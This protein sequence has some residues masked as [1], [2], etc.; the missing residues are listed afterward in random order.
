[1]SLAF[2]GEFDAS[3]ESLKLSFEERA[4]LKSGHNVSTPQSPEEEEALRCQREGI[5]LSEEM[6][7]ILK[8]MNLHP[9]HSCSTLNPDSTQILGLLRDKFIPYEDNLFHPQISGTN[10]IEIP[11][12]LLFSK[13]ITLFGSFLPQ[14]KP[15]NDRGEVITK[16]DELILFYKKILEKIN[17]GEKTEIPG[18]SSINS[19]S[20]K[21]EFQNIFREQ[22]KRSWLE[23]FVLN[24]DPKDDEN[25]KI[26]NSDEFISTIQKVI[27][28]SGSVPVIISSK[29]LTSSNSVEIYHVFERKIKN[30]I[31][32]IA[33]AYDPK[34]QGK[35]TVSRSEWK[36][37]Q[38]EKQSNEIYCPNQITL[39]KT[40]EK[41]VIF[42]DSLSLHQDA[43]KDHKRLIRLTRIQCQRELNCGN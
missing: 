6:K 13:K 36:K 4:D 35:Y 34:D 41:S 31:Q 23:S 20:E 14:E 16:G 11:G 8:K 3:L 33:C 43:L 39:K 9:C 38:K 10:G 42:N 28:E 24:S 2:C 19:F 12:F 7:E 40:I 32:L 22:I 18:F 1:M 5:P 29:D 21:P 27:Q 26:I 37:I 15:R 25:K 17:R 30:E